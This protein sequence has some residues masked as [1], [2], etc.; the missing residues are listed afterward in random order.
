MEEKRGSI[1]FF[2]TYRPPVPLDI[3]SCPNPPASPRQ[4]ELHMT[5]G[6]SYNYNAQVI[7][8]AALKAILKRP[9]LASEAAKDADVDSGR[10]SGIVFVSERANLETLHFALRFNDVSSPKVKVFSFSD[11]YGTFDGVRMEDSGRFAGDYLV[12]VTTKDDPD[13]RRQPWTAVYKTNLKTGKTERL[14]PSGY[15][16][17]AFFVATVETEAS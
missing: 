5:D 7:P 12:Y 16:S 1:A 2:S 10:V 14:T 3:Y 13:D 6:E 8:P 15:L 9:K 4:T 17:F 11:V